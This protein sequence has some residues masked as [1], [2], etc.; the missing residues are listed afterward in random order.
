MLEPPLV[1]VVVPTYN[2]AYLVGRTVESILAQRY[3]NFELL[4]VNDGGTDTTAEA[5]AGYRDSRLSY[6]VKTNG[7][8]ASARNFGLAQAR[9]D[10]VAFCD[11]DDCW[12]PEKLET[13][14]RFLKEHPDV[15]VCYTGSVIHENGRDLHY[16][17]RQITGDPL[18]TLLFVNPATTPAYLIKKECFTKVGYFDPSFTAVEDHLLWL[19]FAKYFTFGGIDKP[20]VRVHRG[21]KGV[22]RDYYQNIVSSNRAVLQELQMIL[23]EM[24]ERIPAGFEKKIIAYTKFKLAKA[25]MYTGRKSRAAAA[26]L[27]S[28]WLNPY[29]SEAWLL[30]AGCLLPTQTFAKAIPRLRRRGTRRL[31]HMPKGVN[32]TW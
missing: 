29:N 1:S 30:L 25:E 8:P 9:G 28:L 10:L 17:F 15:A 12:F 19:K 16:Y 13:Q 20:L 11:D 23:R 32:I 4:V 3:R 24:P 2:R 14:V 21:E 18:I 31:P 26:S 5:V 7:G 6:L 27:A 22:G